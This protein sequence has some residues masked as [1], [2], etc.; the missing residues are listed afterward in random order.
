MENDD[1][2]ADVGEGEGEGGGGGGGWIREDRGWEE[3]RRGCD[4]RL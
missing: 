3:W 4:K 1:C 2:F